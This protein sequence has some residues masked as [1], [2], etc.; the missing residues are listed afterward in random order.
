MAIIDPP[1]A[2]R[3]TKYRD[4]QRYFWLNL[5]DIDDREVRTHVAQIMVEHVERS[6][7]RFLSDGLSETERFDQIWGSDNVSE[8]YGGFRNIG[9]TYLWLS[10]FFPSYAAKT[11]PASLGIRHYM[12]A[13]KTAYQYAVSVRANLRL[14]DGGLCS[15]MATGFEGLTRAV[16]ELKMRTDASI[17]T[18]PGEVVEEVSE[19]MYRGAPIKLEKLADRVPLRSV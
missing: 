14:P 2:P 7:L 9:D 19:A 11:R 1:S 6:R 18:L 17:V 4:L 15:K 8:R 13:G 16:F 5:K 10:G 12:E 3:P